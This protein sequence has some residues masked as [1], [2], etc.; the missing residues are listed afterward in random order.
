MLYTIH[1]TTY[2]AQCMTHTIYSYK[3]HSIHNT[4]R[5][6]HPFHYPLYNMQY[7]MYSGHPALYRFT[8]HST[9]YTTHYKYTIYNALDTII[10]YT[11]NIT[12][13]TCTQYNIKDALY[14]IVHYKL[15][16]I[17]DTCTLYITHWALHTTHSTL[18]STPYTLYNACCTV[19]SIHCILY[20]THHLHTT[21][22]MD[23]TTQCAPNTLHHKLP[24]SIVTIT[25]A[26]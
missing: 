4:L 16:I 15:H 22:Y 5:T 13:Y 3:L 17:H 8:I 26:L 10:H 14:A 9:S 23:N 19:S 20:D 11:L 6:R 2:I 21:P 25:H 18:S 7:E 1:C 24:I 12:H